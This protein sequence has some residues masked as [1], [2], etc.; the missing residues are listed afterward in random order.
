MSRTAMLVQVSAGD[1]HNKFYEL[2]L[3]GE[4]VRARWGRVGATGQS[5]TYAGG[6]REFNRRKAAKMRGGYVEVATAGDTGQGSA[7]KDV[8][9]TAATTA[10]AASTDP[11]VLNLI[12]YLVAKNAHEI[13]T[14]SGGKIVVKN[15]QATTA[16]GPVTKFAI[17]QAR[18]VLDDLE[19]ESAR[20]GADRVTLLERYL[21][22]IPQTVPSR[23]GW[24]EHYLSSAGEFERQRQF[25]DQLDAATDISFDGPTPQVAFAYILEAPGDVAA[26]KESLKRFKASL[27]RMHAPHVTG[28]RL[29]A[30]YDLTPC[31]QTGAIYADRLAD[32][33]NPKFLYHSSRDFNILSILSRGLLT[34]RQTTGLQTAGAMFG[35]GLYGSECSTKALG[36]GAGVWSGT[37]ED[38]FF[39]FEA[40]MV[41]GNTYQPTGTYRGT[42]HFD[43][44]LNGQVKDSRGHRYHSISVAPGT[45]NVR[46]HEA[47]VPNASQILLTRLLE[48]RS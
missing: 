23:R 39:M 31:A 36:Y 14:T 40:E 19:R 4:S 10:L 24:E 37:R 45:Q 16:L 2:T 18:T 47:I 7:S 17:S 48:F 13:A 25:L 5:M 26:I 33:G 27:N 1:N 29:T 8:L 30:V 6:E 20:K 22:L 32:L 28:A 9:R 42:T 38:R 21:T 34:P 15:G 35:H 41:L 12:D 43:A 3:D 11:A 46:N 44:V